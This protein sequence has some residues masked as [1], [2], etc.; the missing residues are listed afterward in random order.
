ML[1]IDNVTVRIGGRII[2]DGASAAISDGRKVGL[3]GRNGAGKTTLLKLILGQRESE[4]GGIEISKSWRVGAVAQEAPAGPQTLIETVLAADSERTELLAAVEKQDDPL[5]LGEV[6]A[7]LDE[8]G[9]YA[10]PARAARILAGL[11]FPESQ[12]HRPC[13]EFSGGWR[14]RVAL[15]AILFAAPDLLL[16]DEPTNYLDL[17]G[18][19]W[20][21]DY[22]K[23]YRGTIVLVSHDRDLLNRA[24]DSI[25][26]LEHGKLTLYSGNYDR[27]VEAREQ[28]RALDAAARA[29]QE[30]ERKRIQAFIDRFRAKAS[31]ASQAQSRMK[32]LEKMKPVTLVV[33]DRLA[34]ITLPQPEAVA[35]PLIALDRVSVGYAPG[36]PVLSHL[37]LRIDSDDRIALLGQ[38]GNGKSTLAKLM[39]G[40]LKPLSGEFTRA[41]KLVT[42]YFAQHQLDELDATKTALETLWAHRPLFDETTARTRLGGF[43]FSGEKADTPITSLSGGERARLLL[44]IATLEKPNLLILDEPTNHLDIDAREELLTALNEYEGAVV[45]ISHDRRLI[46]ACA[47]RLLLVAEGRVTHFEG[48]MEDYKR[49]VLSARGG[50]NDSPVRESKT[51]SKADQRREAADRRIALKPLKDAMDKWEREVARLHGEIEKCDAEL[52]SPG[53]FAKDPAKGEKLSKARAEAARKLEAAEGSWIE[54]A[55][56]YEAAQAQTP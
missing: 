23:R 50:A 24:V 8:I 10:A 4:T 20:L 45:L 26:H 11:G 56:T 42:G 51:Q 7:R 28:K 35:P 19:L 25:L 37:S 49:L 44:A 6:H 43:G 13:S 15:A 33:S 46:E 3:I 12:Q 14:M 30:A 9:A 52:A 39:A 32:W 31:K 2:L 17:E 16:L 36:K 5:K 27:F 1:I 40:R 47:D 21:E 34:A 41:R 29:Q 54:A 48:D 22:L 55:E 18:A 53:L 38:N